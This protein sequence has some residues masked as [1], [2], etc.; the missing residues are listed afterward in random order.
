M[1]EQ[2]RGEN[3]WLSNFA[4]VPIIIDGISYKSVE[5]A[6]IASKSNS[7]EWKELCSSGIYSAGQ[8]KRV[9]SDSDLIDNWHDIKYG[10]MKD[11]LI[12][13]YTQEPFKTKLI[14]T[15]DTHIQEGNY[16]NDKYWGVCLKTNEGKNILGNLIME[17][18]ESIQ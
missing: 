15:G 17:I 14:N 18:R 2:F 8:L 12:Q 6:Y 13:K 5:H 7:P 10:I 11:L 1:I 16:W 4:D 3:A 9:W